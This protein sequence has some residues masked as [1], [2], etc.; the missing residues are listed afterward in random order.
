MYRLYGIPTQNTL[1]AA[2]V[3]DAVGAD[4]EFQKVDLS[5][6]EQKTEAFLKV[7]PIG[8]VPALKHNDFTL[9]ESGALCRYIANVENSPLY[10]TD[11]QKRAQVDQWLDFF[12]CHLGR[13]LSALFYEQVIKK[14]SGRGEPDKARCEE[15]LGFVNQQILPVEKHLSQSPYFVGDQLTI[16]DLVAFAYIEQSAALNYDLSPYPHTKKWLEKVGSLD[17][18]KKTKTKV[19]WG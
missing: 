15:A 18:V 10:P 14:A 6:G 19:Q 3:L 16:A 4:Y 11:K 5:K 9:F 13:W 2:Y 7:N 17:S 8:K 12:T 1:K